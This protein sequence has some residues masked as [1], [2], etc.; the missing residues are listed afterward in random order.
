MG[1]FVFFF[2]GGMLFVGVSK[3]CLF[4]VRLIW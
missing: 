4:E 2:W 1:V 3:F